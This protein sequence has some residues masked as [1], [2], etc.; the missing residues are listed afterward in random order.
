MGAPD[1]SCFVC[2][3]SQ[4]G[5]S[6]LGRS[7]VS[8]APVL[9]RDDALLERVEARLHTSSNQPERQ[10]E[11][12]DRVVHAGLAVAD[13]DGHLI[14]EAV[15]DHADDDQQNQD[16]DHPD[17]VAVEKPASQRS[18]SIQTV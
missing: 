16:E 13:A 1:R 17:P 9:R 2:L 5:D 12:L 3:V 14:A 7:E 8:C 15:G 18:R 6:R 10:Q 11:E 4:T